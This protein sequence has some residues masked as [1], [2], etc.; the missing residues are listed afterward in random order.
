MPRRWSAP[1]RAGPHGGRPGAS[2]HQAGLSRHRPVAPARREPA[3]AQRGDARRQR[4]PAHAVQ[5]FPR[6]ELGRLQQA[7]AGLG[8]RRDGGRQP[9]ARGARHQRGL[10]RELSGRSRP[11]PDRA[12]GRHRDDRAGRAAHDPLRGAAPPS[13]QHAADRDRARARRAHH[14]HHGAGAALGE[15]LALPQDPRPGILRFRGRVGRGGARPR[16][17]RGARL[18]HRAGRRRERAVALARGRGGAHG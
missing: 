13:G 16:R 4:A 8:L 3:I 9:P 1:R 17:G 6:H 18:P 2:G 7:R 12:R 14:L 5:L 10:H 11:E 15:A